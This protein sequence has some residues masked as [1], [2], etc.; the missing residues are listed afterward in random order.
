MMEVER[1]VLLFQS[2]RISMA[3]SCNRKPGKNPG[4]DP[5]LI[6]S[7]EPGTSDQTNIL[8]Q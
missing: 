1:A 3:W 2:F 4:E 7:Q 8:L 5:I 6:V